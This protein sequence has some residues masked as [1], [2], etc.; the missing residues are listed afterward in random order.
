VTLHVIM[1]VKGPSSSPID[2]G[3]AIS[4]QAKATVR[5]FLSLSELACETD[6]STR[7][8]QKEIARGRLK[9]LRLSNRITRIRRSDFENYLQLAATIR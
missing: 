8:W 4:K 9:A 2:E 6:T 5:G 1:D 3:G 7:F